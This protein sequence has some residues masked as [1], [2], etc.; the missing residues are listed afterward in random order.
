MASSSSSSLTLPLQ[1]LRYGTSS[2]HVGLRR[3]LY[4]P[5][6]PSIRL[7][8]ARG[9]RPVAAVASYHDEASG[10]CAGAGD[11]GIVAA[12]TSV[13]LHQVADDAAAAAELR[14]ARCVGRAPQ[15]P[16]GRSGKPKEGG[17]GKVHAAPPTAAAKPVPRAPA[18]PGLP[19]ER[20]GGQGG[21]IH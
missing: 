20:S 11:D 2:S 17:G 8:A 13:G 6:P 21:K 16:K 1:L 3:P 9:L 18:P 19:K 10:G 4:R 7:L 12:A 5:S 14:A 15:P